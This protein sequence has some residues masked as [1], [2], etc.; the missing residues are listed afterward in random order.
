[1]N[2]KTKKK[3]ILLAIPLAIFAIYYNHIDI[4]NHNKAVEELKS[5]TENK[6]TDNKIAVINDTSTVSIPKAKPSKTTSNKVEYSASSMIAITAFK[7]KDYYISIVAMVEGYRSKPYRDNI[8]QA[9]A[10]GYNYTFQSIASNTE[11]TTKANLDKDMIKD[12]V[13]LSAKANDKSG[14][15][16]IL[17]LPGSVAINPDQA[18]SI[19]NS[20]KPVFENGMIKL[21]GKENWNKLDENKKA[22]L[23]Y[24]PEKVGLGGIQ[25]Y[26]GLISAV[27]EYAKNPT[28]ENAEKAAMHIDFTYKIIK[29][30]QTVVMHDERS[31]K[32]MRAL[33]VD[34]Q[35]YG[36]LLG[37]DKAPANFKEIS[38][39]IALNIDKTKNPESQINDSDDYGRMQQENI[40]GESKFK[41]VP[42]LNG[43]ELNYNNPPIEQNK[44]THA[45]Y[46]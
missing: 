1:M 13:S 18:I 2:I 14:Q 38:D 45:R 7:E 33:F 39:R 28:Q 12:I 16:L 17:P 11:W 23:V 31:A 44:G 19:A 5:I 42:V 34:P 37:A 8:G 36:F 27:K 24:C 20:M 25:K 43:K 10:F 21:I 22:V 35:S 46:M 29:D 26:K 32:Y 6:V 30:G 9:V 3:L 41:I 15:P 40:D 4:A